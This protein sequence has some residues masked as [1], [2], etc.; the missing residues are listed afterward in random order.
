[1]CQNRCI[2]WGFEH[3][4]P[5]VNVLDENGDNSNAFHVSCAFG[6]TRPFCLSDAVG[7]TQGA[8]ERG[9]ADVETEAEGSEVTQFPQGDPVEPGLE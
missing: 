7:F 3:R 5:W 4:G 6:L 8:W 9:N 2:G 1:M